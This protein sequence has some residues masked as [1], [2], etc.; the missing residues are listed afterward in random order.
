MGYNYKVEVTSDNY[1]VSSTSPKDGILNP[2]T[3]VTFTIDFKSGA[4]SYCGWRHSSQ[5]FHVQKYD[6][7]NIA[8]SFQW[9]KPAGALKS[10]H[11]N[12]KDDPHGIV[13]VNSEHSIYIGYPR[14]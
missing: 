3:G 11:I 4:F 1:C 7:P 13:H 8:A 14:K 10:A 2:G 12:V 5:L 6:D 9:Y